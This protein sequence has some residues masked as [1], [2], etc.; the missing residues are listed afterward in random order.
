MYSSWSGFVVVSDTYYS[1]STLTVTAEGVIT[2]KIKGQVEYVF[3]PN[4]VAPVEPEV[5]VMDN[6]VRANYKSGKLQFFHQVDGANVYC[7][8]FYNYDAVNTDGMFIPEGEYVVG[9]NFYVYGYSNVY[10][11]VAKGYNYDFDEGGVM[12]VSGGRT[13]ACRSYS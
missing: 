8:G 13:E 3:D 9:Y 5:L 7:A 6:I 2:W 11:Y 12:N 1:D 10:D 4:A